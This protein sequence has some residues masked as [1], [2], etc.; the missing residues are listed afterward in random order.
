MT[1]KVLLSI[2][3]LP[4]ILFCLL[5]AI[6]I[7]QTYTNIFRLKKGD[8]SAVLSSTPSKC[9]K[10]KDCP[11]LPGD[12]LIRRYITKNVWL[13]NTVVRVFFTHVALYLGNNQVVEAHG[14]ENK[15]EDDIRVDSLSNSIWVQDDV[16]NWV[17]LRPKKNTDKIGQMVKHLSA[18]ADD[19]EYIFGLPKIGHKK[20]MCADL[21]LNELQ[22]QGIIPPVS[23][24]KIITPDYLFW[25]T[26]N[27]PNNFEIVGYSFEK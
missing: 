18:I 9:D 24:V 14:R 21:I 8:V 26:V 10:I 1:K 4:I 27:T 22:T 17:I 15:P 13:A 19:P 11:L 12:I 3:I 23:T 2:L 16:K 25:N 5:V 6:N 20:A 7:H